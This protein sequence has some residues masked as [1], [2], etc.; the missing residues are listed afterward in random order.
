M[1]VLMTLVAWAAISFLFT[2]LWGNAIARG[3]E[4]PDASSQQS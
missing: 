4:A 3:D 1:R 2:W